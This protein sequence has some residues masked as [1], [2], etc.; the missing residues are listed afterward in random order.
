LGLSIGYLLATEMQWAE[1]LFLFVERFAEAT[2]LNA[3]MRPATPAE[4]GH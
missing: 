1:Y 3:V 2:R 4:L